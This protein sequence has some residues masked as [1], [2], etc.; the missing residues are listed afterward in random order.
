MAGGWLRRYEVV[1]KRGEPE[2]L[3]WFWAR[4]RGGSNISGGLRGRAEFVG[5][6]KA[7]AFDPALSGGEKKVYSAVHRCLYL[8]SRA[9]QPRKRREWRFC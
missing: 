6:P 5:V 1:R 9:A 4:E 7:I 8:S 3:R 2:R